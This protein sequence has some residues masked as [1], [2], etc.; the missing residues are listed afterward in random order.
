MCNMKYWLNLPLL[1]L[2]N[3]VINGRKKKV[4]SGHVQLVSKATT[5]SFCSYFLLCEL[6]SRMNKTPAAF[7]LVILTGLAVSVLG[8]L[9]NSVSNSS[10]GLTCRI[11][12]AS[13]YYLWLRQIVALISECCEWR[14]TRA[15]QGAHEWHNS[16]DSRLL[17][18]CWSF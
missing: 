10:L 17:P 4:Y 7:P 6:C 5:F 18:S 14:P 1:L 8:I 13:E 15:F 16:K 11:I 2:R 9:P 3:V 12:I